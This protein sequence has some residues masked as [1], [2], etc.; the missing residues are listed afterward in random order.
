MR[1]PTRV[2]PGP[3]PGARGVEIR[4]LDLV[5][6]LEIIAREDLAV[7]G[8]R[9]HLSARAAAV[10]ALPGKVDVVV[11][12]GGE[13]AA[14]AHAC[15]GGRAQQTRCACQPFG[16]VHRWRLYGKSFEHCEGSCLV[17]S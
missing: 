3:R 7:G 11:S 15:T 13:T 6:D 1:S 12:G 4:G 2:P 10:I 9:R 8:R 17:I 14:T 5:R 16:G